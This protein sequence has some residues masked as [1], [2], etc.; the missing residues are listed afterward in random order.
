MQSVKQC[1]FKGLKDF[2]RHRLEITQLPLNPIY[3]KYLKILCFCFL[4]AEW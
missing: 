2:D 4:Y 3:L 1:P